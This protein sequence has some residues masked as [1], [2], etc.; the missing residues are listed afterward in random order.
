MSEQIY[1]QDEIFAAVLPLLKKYH[2]EKAILFGSYAR[3]D[4]D[5]ASDIDLIVVGGKDFD[6][7]DVLCIAEE[8]LCAFWESLWTSMNCGRSIPSR[9]SMMQ[10]W[11]RGCR[12]HEI[13]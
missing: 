2:A 6:L 4:A 9:L 13:Q 10:F 5:A 1:S 12:L 3:Q 11:P 8:L 7:T